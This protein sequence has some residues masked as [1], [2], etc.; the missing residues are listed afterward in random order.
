M[1]LKY[2]YARI[3]IAKSSPPLRGD[4]YENSLEI[5]LPCFFRTKE[6]FHSPSFEWCDA[7]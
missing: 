1:Y 6:Y 4:G 5:F 3:K 7:S 2:M